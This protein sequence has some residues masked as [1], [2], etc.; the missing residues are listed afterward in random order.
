MKKE[1]ERF[2]EYGANGRVDYAIYEDED[3]N[4]WKERVGG[5]SRNDLLGFEDDEQWE[6][7]MF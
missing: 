2:S 4:R 3:G 5:A 1:V 7:N 6:D